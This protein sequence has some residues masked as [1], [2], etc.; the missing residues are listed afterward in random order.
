MSLPKALQGAR[1]TGLKLTWTQDD[2][3]V[4]NL[5]G[6]TLSGT[7]KDKDGVVTAITGTLAIVTAA[8]GIFSWAYSAADIATPGRYLVQFKA[9][10]TEYDLTY[11]ENWE[12]EE[13]ITV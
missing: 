11:P 10:F 6:A 3:T 12:V 9:T 5:T 1:N 7:M 4:E 13:A 8:S 2:G